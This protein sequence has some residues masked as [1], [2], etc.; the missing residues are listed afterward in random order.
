MRVE[1]GGTSSPTPGRQGSLVTGTRAYHSRARAMRAGPMTRNRRPPIRPA[2]V[3]TRVERTV[4]MI[5]TGSPVR[6]APSAE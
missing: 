2:I 4:S 3:P 6:A 1:T 5:P